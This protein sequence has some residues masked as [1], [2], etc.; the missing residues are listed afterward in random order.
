MRLW[1]D[2]LGVFPSWNGTESSHY[3]YVRVWSTNLKEATL[4]N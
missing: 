2:L 4:D 1:F 3:L